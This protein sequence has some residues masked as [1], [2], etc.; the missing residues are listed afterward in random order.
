VTPP[1]SWAALVCGWLLRVPLLVSIAI[2]VAI[3]LLLLVTAIVSGT[4][5][6]LF[7]LGLRF[8]VCLIRLVL[9]VTVTIHVALLLLLGLAVLIA[10]LNLIGSFQTHRMVWITPLA[11]ATADEIISQRNKV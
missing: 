2:P 11:T 1:A 7:L 4:F 3:P 5:L 8:A 6:L 9:S 10:L